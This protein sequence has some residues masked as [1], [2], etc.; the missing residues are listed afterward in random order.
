[1]TF[2]H[3]HL[4]NIWFR[5]THPL[6]QHCGSAHS[7]FS[8]WI[9]SFNLSLSR[10]RGF[11]SWWAITYLRENV[12]WSQ[13]CLPFPTGL[14]LCVPSTTER[15][16]NTGREG[17]SAEGHSFYFCTSLGNSRPLLLYL[18]D[19]Q[20]HLPPNR[21]RWTVD[22]RQI[23]VKSVTHSPTMKTWQ[24][25]QSACTQTHSRQGSRNGCAII[26]ETRMHYTVSSYFS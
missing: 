2:Y 25:A 21:K 19:W 14:F 12:C 1:M 23:V 5:C 18:A 9:H 26:Q 10:I 24:G 17:D 6:R 13:L 8:N 15:G 16:F 20:Y 11:K 4:N 3:Y 22:L 7:H